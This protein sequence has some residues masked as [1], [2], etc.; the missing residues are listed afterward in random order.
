MW[1]APENSDTPDSGEVSDLDDQAFN[2]MEDNV[3]RLAAETAKRTDPEPFATRHDPSA[4]I[5]TE[6]DFK[7][8][9]R[10]AIDELPD[11]AQE[12]LE[13]VVITVSDEGHKEH[14]YGR[15]SGRT[16]SYTYQF[17]RPD[18]GPAFNVITIYRD[19]L[20]R[21]FGNDPAGLR[22]QITRTVRHEVAHHLGFNEDEVRR[23][24][25]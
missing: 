20:T 6:E 15:Y 13:N 1:F 4:P 25:L 17:S 23:L 3:E 24:G 2:A 11:G 14:A 9:V 8:A 16:S 21:D 12:A 18:P 10:D 22:A 19:T 7:Q 5:R